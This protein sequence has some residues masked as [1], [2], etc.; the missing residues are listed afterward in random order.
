MYI[1]QETSEQTEQRLIEVLRQANWTIYQGAYFF[2]EFPLEQYQFDPTA[3]AIVRDE[4]IWSQLVKTSD[5]E[6]NIER[7]R[8]FSFHFKDGADNSGFV[9]WLA[10]TIKSKTGSGV[11][12]VCGQNTNRGGIFDYWGC[13]LEVGNQ[14]IN[15]IEEMRANP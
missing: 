10:S 9:G 13:P 7:F 15:L 14:I 4:E 8:V 5:Q 6:K 12:V 3:L 11:F 2:E 1:S